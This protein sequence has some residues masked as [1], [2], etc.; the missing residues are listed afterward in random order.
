MRGRDWSMSGAPEESRVCRNLKEAAGVH[1]TLPQTMRAA[2]LRD[3]DLGHRTA[4][5]FDCHLPP[6]SHVDAEEFTSS[7]GP[8]SVLGARL[9][10]VTG[11]GVD[12]TS[13]GATGGLPSNELQECIERLLRQKLAK[14]RR[15][16]NEDIGALRLH[17]SAVAAVGVVVEELATDM[18][19]RWRQA[20]RVRCDQARRQ[21]DEGEGGGGFGDEVV[22]GPF[23]SSLQSADML[24]EDILFQAAAMQARGMD[25]Q[26]LNVVGP[27]EDFEP[28]LPQLRN[29]MEV[30]LCDGSILYN[31]Y[32]I[33]SIGQLTTDPSRCLL[34]CAVCRCCSG[35]T[36][37][38][39][40]K[41]RRFCGYCVLSKNDKQRL[42]E[43]KRRR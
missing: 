34:C 15:Q 14:R 40:I 1:P 33:K 4:R 13:G 42:L 23:S 5:L 37:L 3:G 12:G 27:L 36:C 26:S 6:P 24:D 43:T 41:T 31:M 39:V 21:G 35:W 10:A 19:E 22:C 25:L 11:G 32:P 17:S 16:G 18:M 2:I 7:V 9:E 28:L 20:I 38:K 29:R 8:R 30:S